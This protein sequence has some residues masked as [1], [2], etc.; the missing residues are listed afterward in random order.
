MK[1]TTSPRI[2]VAPPVILVQDPAP[3][4]AR[5]SEQRSAESERTPVE[6]DVLINPEIERVGD[7]GRSFFEGFQSVDG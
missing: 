3:V 4:H 2:G 6:P 7:E 1:S 5:V